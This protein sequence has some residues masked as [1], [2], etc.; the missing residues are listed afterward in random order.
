MLIALVVA[1]MT[2]LKPPPLTAAQ[3][4]QKAAETQYTLDTKCARANGVTAP[5]PP[6]GV[7]KIPSPVVPP[8]PKGSTVLSLDSITMN[9]ATRPTPHFL[10]LGLSLLF[11]AGPDITTVKDNN[12]G[13]PALNY[14]ILQLQQKKMADL[15]NVESIQQQYSYKICSDPTLNDGGSSPTRSSW[16]S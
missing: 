13:A 15:K 1:K 7:N 2:V 6:K 5:D 8:T 3:K 4:K 14:V 11:P 9:L 10:K 12:P 16:T